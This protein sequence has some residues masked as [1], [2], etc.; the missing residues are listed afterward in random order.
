[1][2][3]LNLMSK[4]KKTASKKAP[5]APKYTGGE[6]YYGNQLV[7]QSYMDPNKGV[8][9]KYTP[10]AEQEESR[11]AAQGRI[12][13]ILPTLGQTSPEMSKQY[14]DISSAWMD[15]QTAAYD[16][17]YQPLLRNLREDYSSRFGGLSNQPYIDALTDAETRQRQPAM[18]DISRQ[19]TLMKQDLY[20]QAQQQ[21]LNELQSLG[22]VLNSDQTNFLNALQNPQQSSQ[23]ANAFNQQNYAAALN[24]YNAERQAQ[25]QNTANLANG[26]FSVLGKF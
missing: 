14:D 4:K 13:Q 16:R 2:K 20:N 12:N 23:Q 26:I 9:T 5:A 17:E 3:W 11:K 21:K 1:M 7:G 25:Q 15:K 8:V 18:L 6:V 10:T 22:Y 24:Q 19:G